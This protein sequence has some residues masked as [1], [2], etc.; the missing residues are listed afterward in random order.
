MRRTQRF[1]IGR[2]PPQNEIARRALQN[3]GDLS[4]LQRQRRVPERWRPVRLGHCAAAVCHQRL[5]GGGRVRRTVDFGKQL[6]R[7]AAVRVPVPGKRNEQ[8]LRL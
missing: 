4:R 6:R 1:F 5:K 7:V 3:T 2:Q 8:P